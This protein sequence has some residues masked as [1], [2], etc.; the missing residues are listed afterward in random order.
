[1]LFVYD[2]IRFIY[3]LIIL[4]RVV[5]VKSIYRSV[6]LSLFLVTN[7]YAENYVYDGV[8]VGMTVEQLKNTSYNNCKVQHEINKS[9]LT[10]SSHQNFYPKFLGASIDDVEIELPD[11]KTVSAINLITS[12]NQD[13]HVLAKKVDGKLS[14]KNNAEIIKIPNHQD[15]LLLLDGRIAIINIS[16]I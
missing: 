7:V 8:F 1:M 13:S 15:G 5:R 11:S 4:A 2:I 14:T 12:Y 6:L 9:W 3:F 16:K 10:C